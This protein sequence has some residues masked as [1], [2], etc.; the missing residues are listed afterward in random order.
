M[1]GRW[2]V[3][4]VSVSPAA[5][6][7]RRSESGAPIPARL[8]R[9]LSGHTEAVVGLAFSPNGELLASGSDDSTAKIW[10]LS[11]G[12]LQQT[13]AQHT[14]DVMSVAFSGDGKWLASSSEDKTIRLW[15]L[16]GSRLAH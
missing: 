16:V 6:S 11:D 13:L 1:S 2:T 9:T 4:T 12:A 8:E 7:T 5:A 15:H 10:H 14:D 3:P